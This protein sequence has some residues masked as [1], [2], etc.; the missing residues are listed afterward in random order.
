MDKK[1]SEWVN[2]DLQLFEKIVFF[3][4]VTTRNGANE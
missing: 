4:V 1:P 2:S 3:D